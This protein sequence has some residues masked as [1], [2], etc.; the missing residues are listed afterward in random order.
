VARAS[1][2]ASKGLAGQRAQPSSSGPAQNHADDSR[3]P[4]SA[5]RRRP[6]AAPSSK[7]LPLPWR[8]GRSRARA[9]LVD[10]ADGEI[11]L[12]RRRWFDA[13][14]AGA[15][16]GEPGE[17]ALVTFAG[18]RQI[19][20]AGID[21]AAVGLDHRRH[22]AVVERVGQGTGA[23]QGGAGLGQGAEI[24]QQRAQVV[25]RVQGLDPIALA[26]GLLAE[27]LPQP[28]RPGPVAGSNRQRRGC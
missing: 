18:R 15:D 7:R 12:D 14:V 5:G 26:L 23:H 25:E 10:A 27:L 6:G 8:R 28:P 24:A 20:V 17:G 4:G 21:L 11:E 19:A 16:A 1:S 2:A 9:R 13:V 3:S 22:V